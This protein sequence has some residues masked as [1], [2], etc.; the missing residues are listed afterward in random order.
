MRKDGKPPVFNNFEHS[1][2]MK[3]NYVVLHD[4]PRDMD[5]R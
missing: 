3:S 1:H 4:E 2:S 5:E